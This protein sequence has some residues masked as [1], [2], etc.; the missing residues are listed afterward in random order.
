MK[1]LKGSVKI[2][3]E[4]QPPLLGSRRQSLSPRMQGKQLPLFALLHE[5]F[6]LFMFRLLT[7]P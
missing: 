6:M 5:R 4:G 3:E 1:G 7:F 2:H